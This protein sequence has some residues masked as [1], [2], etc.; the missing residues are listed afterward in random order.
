MFQ[1]FFIV[2]TVDDY[3]VCDDSFLAGFLVCYVNELRNFRMLITEWK[4]ESMRKDINLVI[5][6]SKYL[7]TSTL[8]LI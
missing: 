1:P 7:P 2:R 8:C 4:W 5:S 6:F 3:F